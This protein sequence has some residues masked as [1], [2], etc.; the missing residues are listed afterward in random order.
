MLKQQPFQAMHKLI[1][2]M[3]A[4]IQQVSSCANRDATAL[5]LKRIVRRLVTH[6]A[7]THLT[8]VRQS[9]TFEG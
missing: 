8:S 7:R 1:S 5:A 9:R 6:C 2:S 4:Y 3:H